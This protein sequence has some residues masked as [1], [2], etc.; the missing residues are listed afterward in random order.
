MPSEVLRPSS[1]AMRARRTYRIAFVLWGL[2]GVFAPLLM[3][4]LGHAEGSEIIAW[5]AFL[6]LI[7]PAI[8]FALI[9]S[10]F[11]TVHV[12]EGLLWGS[13]HSPPVLKPA[14]IAVV[15][16][17]PAVIGILWSFRRPKETETEPRHSVPYS[18]GGDRGIR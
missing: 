10:R 14:G 2:I 9:D 11:G 7:L 16:L 5:F 4:P 17:I 13:A 12:T 6:P 3:M 8:L 15:Y 1:K 18:P